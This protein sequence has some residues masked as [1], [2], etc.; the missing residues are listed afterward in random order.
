M[1]YTVEQIKEL[2]D[3]HYNIL[4]KKESGLNEHRTTLN[5]LAPDDMEKL[6]AKIIQSCPAEEFNELIGIISQFESENNHENTFYMVIKRAYLNSALSSDNPYS[7]LG[8]AD[9][10]AIYKDELND[11]ADEVRKGLSIRLIMN[12]PAEN[13]RSFFH[14]I[15]A[16]TDPV[17]RAQ[18]IYTV[19]SQAYK[20]KNSLLSLMDD[21]N[22]EPHLMILGQFDIELFNEYNALASDILRGNELEIAQKLAKTTPQE[23]HNDLKLKLGQ[24][25][26]NSP[27]TTKTGHAFTVCRNID[28]LLLGETPH[29]FFSDEDFNPGA[30]GEFSELITEAI[31]DKE[32]TIAAKIALHAHTNDV[33]REVQAN[34]QN[35]CISE[36]ELALKIQSAFTL[37][38][39]IDLYLLGEKPE[40]FFSSRDF[41]L[42]SCNEFSLL[43]SELLRGKEQQI[44]E[45]LSHVTDPRLYSSISRNLALMNNAAHDS[46]NPFRLIASVMGKTADK[47]HSQQNSD[48]SHSSSIFHKRNIKLLKPA[49]AVASSADTSNDESTPDDSWTCCGLFK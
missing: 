11:L 6:A 8:T 31:K 5:Q 17:D 36:N 32:S 45:A 27:L 21:R 42:D 34:L 19:M 16:L 30:Y 14:A 3:N 7:M 18:S 38:R 46:T 28:N 2:S 33:R 15:E 35:I 39:N 24:L 47:K 40:L 9:A 41:D 26:L 29:Q 13:M 25:F 20:V 44:G 43:L 1:T 12:C 49:D 4:C 37:R 10:L 23:L 48:S 22:K